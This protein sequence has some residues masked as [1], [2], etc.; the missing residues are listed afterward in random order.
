MIRLWMVAGVLVAAAACAP[1][2]S[3]EITNTLAETPEGGTFNGHWK[4]QCGASYG[5]WGTWDLMGDGVAEL[6]F[7]PDA[8]GDRS[9]DALSIEIIVGVWN[10][11]LVEGATLGVDQLGGTALLNPCVSCPQDTASLT[12]GTIEVLA[13]PEGDPC[14]IEDGPTFKLRWDLVFGDGVGP[15]YEATGTDAV[16]LSTFL[17]EVCGGF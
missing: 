9:W 4:E 3:Y 15:T 16:Q 6:W 11:D 10:T 5:T 7:D 8:A 17:S 1:C 13:G 12:S 2:G 14:D